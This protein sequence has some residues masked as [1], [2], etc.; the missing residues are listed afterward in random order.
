MLC[1]QLRLG[2]L[3]AVKA[4]RKAEA[5]AQIRG[6]LAWE[7]TEEWN[8]K[9]NAVINAVSVAMPARCVILWPVVS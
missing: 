5:A 6:Q 2:D 4:K 8:T 7:E 3:E 1:A 9:N